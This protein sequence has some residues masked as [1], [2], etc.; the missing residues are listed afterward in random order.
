MDAPAAW[1]TELGRRADLPAAAVDALADRLGRDRI[2]FRTAWR[3][4]TTAD[5]ARFWDG[6]HADPG[7]PVVRALTEVSVGKTSAAPDAVAGAT[8]GSDPFPALRELAA[9]V[10]PAAAPAVLFT[11]AAAADPPRWL[12]EVA[13]GVAGWAAR[14]PAV[15]TAVTVPAAAWEAYRSA[16]PE[17]RAKAML[18][19]GVIEIPVLGPGAVARALADAG[20]GP[21]AETAAAVLAAGGATDDLVAAAAEA[22]R[23]NLTPPADPDADDRARSTAE[24]FLF[25][26]LESIPDTAGRFELN[27]TLDFRF[28]PRPAEVDLLARSDRVAVEVDGYF[29]FRGPDDYRRDRDKDYEL[30]RRGYVVLRFLADD[31]VRRVELVRDRILEALARPTEERL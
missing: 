30:Q 2:D 29:H 18:G 25:D 11:P 23:A 8:R 28:G 1:V 24:R 4:K 7:G 20:L 16:A 22:V 3:A 27:G 19:Q 26:L 14:L 6:V 5:R 12:A 9:L 21:E 15:P 10:P 17:S 13:A 31:V